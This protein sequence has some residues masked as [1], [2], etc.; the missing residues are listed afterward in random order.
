MGSKDYLN[1]YHSLL[2]NYYCNQIQTSSKDFK[3]KK[4]IE[5][6]QI[7]KQSR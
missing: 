4:V 2:I 3:I 1:T 7:L 6:K 5:L